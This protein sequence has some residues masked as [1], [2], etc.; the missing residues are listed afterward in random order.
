MGCIRVIYRKK[1]YFDYVSSDMLDNLINR[2][3]ISHFYRPSEKRWISV[4]RDVIRGMGGSYQGAE[5][6]KANTAP[7]ALK[8][9]VGRGPSNTWV[10]E[11][12]W[13]E[14]LWQQVEDL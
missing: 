10:Y 6:R 8:Q 1:E 7:E 13:L 2:D 4:R 3:E 11:T 12:K 9:K 14:S 5:R